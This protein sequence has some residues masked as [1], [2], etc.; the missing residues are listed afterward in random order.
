[1]VFIVLNL[2]FYS[3]APLSLL[4]VGDWKQDTHLPVLLWIVEKKHGA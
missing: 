2:R 3:A 4:F 1:M